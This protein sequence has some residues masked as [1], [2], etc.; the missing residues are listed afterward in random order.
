MSPCTSCAAVVFESG[1]CETGGVEVQACSRHV[2]SQ[3][4]ITAQ[5]WLGWSFGPQND[6][7]QE[8]ADTLGCRA[9]LEHL[10]GALAA[11][12]TQ[13]DHRSAFTVFP[14]HASIPL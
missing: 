13:S 5:L 4:Y 2:V 12:V 3:V 10:S 11:A 14:A 9:S 1:V 7:C 6:R 8:V